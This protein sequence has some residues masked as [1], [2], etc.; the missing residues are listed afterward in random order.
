M[1]EKDLSE[2]S[3]EGFNEVFADIVNVLMFEGKDVVKPEELSDALPNSFFKLDGKLREQERDV[4]KYW[5]NGEI[6]LSYIGL[7]NQTAIDKFMPMRITSYDGAVY[8]GQL[9]E[10]E[11][12]IKSAYKEKREPRKIDFY[13]VVTLVL[14]FGERRWTKYRELFD[15]FNISEELKPFVTNYKINVIEMSYLSREQVDMFKSDFYFVAD[16]FWQ[17]H[18]NKDYNPPAE[19]VVHVNEIMD[20]LKSF[21]KNIDFENLKITNSTDGGPHMFDEWLI[22][23][24]D[25]AAIA[26]LKEGVSVEKVARCLRLSVEH[27]KELAEQLEKQQVE[28]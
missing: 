22:K 2:K 25:K 10:F 6:R 21:T 5:K 11:S 28:V 18:N 20:L 12:E 17:V 27:V 3:L 19:L 8:K 23:R 16:Y 9:N 1:A 7:E 24:D 14:Y 15:C 13:P 4:A 26:F